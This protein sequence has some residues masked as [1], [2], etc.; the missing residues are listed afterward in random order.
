LKRAFS[1]KIYCIFL[2]RR[3]CAIKILDFAGNAA[4][5]CCS[6]LLLTASAHLEAEFFNLT[7]LKN[8]TLFLFFKLLTSKKTFD[9]IK[10]RE[11]HTNGGLVVPQPVLSAIPIFV[12]IL[13][14][15]CF[16]KTE[17]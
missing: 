14:R 3:R 13:F 6:V 7:R 16:A 15:K 10:L 1:K 12:Y 17:A 4:H 11:V 8:S 5:F 2:R 9:K